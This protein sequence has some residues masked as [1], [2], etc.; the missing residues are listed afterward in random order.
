MK[1]FSFNSLDTLPDLSEL[2]SLFALN[3]YSLMISSML[4]GSSFILIKD[5]RLKDDFG[6]L[7]LSESSVDWDIILL[8]FI[9]DD[10]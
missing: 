1:S 5:S 3:S 9:M 2:V 8:A 10:P 6:T 4:S 7:T